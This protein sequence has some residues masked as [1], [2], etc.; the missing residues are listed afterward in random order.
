MTPCW[1]VTVAP[2]FWIPHTMRL[3]PSVH[4]TT[5]ASGKVVSQSSSQLA[6][7]MASISSQSPRVLLGY[8]PAT[9]LWDKG[10]E[11][12]KVWWVD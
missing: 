4:K 10:S 8:H 1:V 7:E 12:L 11:C 9:V 3:F 2:T 5:S 6:Y